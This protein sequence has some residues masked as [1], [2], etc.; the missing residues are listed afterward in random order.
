MKH[1]AIFG[2]TLLAAGLPAAAMAQDC[3]LKQVTSLDLL[4]PNSSRALVPVTVNDV[5]KIFMLDTGG[6]TT[7]ISPAAARDLNMKFYRTNTELHDVSGNISQDFVAAKTFQ[8][9]SLHAE[10]ARMMVSPD[11]FGADGLLS[12]DMLFR[13]DIE[14]D[15]GGRKLNYFSQDHCPGKVVYWKPDAVAVVPLRLRDRTRIEI[16]V[17]VDGKKFDALVDTGA[18]RTTMSLPA[19]LGVFG[20]E[21][22]SPGVTVA[23]NVGGDSKLASYYHVFSTLSFEG[24]NVIHP[25]ILLMPDRMAGNRAV[26]GSRI[27]SGDA[28]LPELI[29]GMDVMRHLRMYFAFN[30]KNAYITAASPAPADPQKVPSGQSEY[31]DSLD[32]ILSLSPSNSSWLN[33]RCFVRGLEN[34]KLDGALADCDRSLDLRPG[35]AATVDSRGLVLYRMGRFA[36]ALDAYDM[37]LRKRR[38]FAASRFMRGHVLKKMG[39]AQEG[40][41]DIAA[42]KAADPDVLS[43]FKG[44]DI[45]TE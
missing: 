21:P 37:A 32:R 43:V 7:Q 22:G 6:Y 29:L 39:K 19:A 44:S 23:G 28:M 10:D 14:M 41:A 20:L 12:S 36:D 1:R 2:L 11:N 15:F 42:A 13:Y 45:P 40:A 34:V 3:G 18:T 9:G 27:P 33:E 35:D 17:T 26:T 4:M 38:D 24:I 31:L 16:E 8:L 5:P 25:K 30:E